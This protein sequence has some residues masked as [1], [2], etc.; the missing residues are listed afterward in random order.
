MIFSAQEGRA[1]PDFQ[2]LLVHIHIL[3]KRAKL[4]LSGGRIQHWITASSRG[5]LLRALRMSKSVVSIGNYCLSR[6]KIGHCIPYICLYCCKY[7]KSGCLG[8][9]TFCLL[10][11]GGSSLISK[12]NVNS[13]WW[14]QKWLLAISMLTARSLIRD[15][16]DVTDITR[17]KDDLSSESNFSGN[18]KILVVSRN[19]F[20]LLSQLADSRHS[21]LV[22]LDSKWGFF[23]VKYIGIPQ[24]NRHK[25][26][27]SQSV[28]ASWLQKKTVLVAGKNLI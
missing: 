8:E 14:V 20:R 22:V 26:D 5:I 23:V 2:T 25:A 15:A 4:W 13:V 12:P 10:P 9:N 3:C 27:S 19:S 24:K 11:I 7:E 1:D 16:Q 6:F 17:V 28:Q 18:S 21:F